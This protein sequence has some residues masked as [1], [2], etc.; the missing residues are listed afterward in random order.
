[1]K[2]NERLKELRLQSAYM[3]KEI[4]ALIGV[5]VRTFQSYE[6]GT[7]EPNITKLIQLA[8]LFN[9][10]LDYLV[11]RDFPKPSLIDTK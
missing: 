4:A 3:Q 2:F 6:H 5:S 10:S 11:C 1:M 7:I 9:V 8:D